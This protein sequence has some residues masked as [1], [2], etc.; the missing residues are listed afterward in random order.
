MP[1]LLLVICTRTRTKCTHT[2]ES[3]L[4]D[5]RWYSLAGYRCWKRH[6]CTH[7]HLHACT[8]KH[9]QTDTHTHTHTQTGLSLVFIGGLSLLEARGRDFKNELVQVRCLS[10][11]VRVCLDVRVYASDGGRAGC[12]L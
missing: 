8:H 3:I 2:D 6:T 12:R 10:V 4:Q 9:K 5:C 11:R 1:T 7:T